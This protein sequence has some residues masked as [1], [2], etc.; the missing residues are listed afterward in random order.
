MK[1]KWGRLKV[2]QDTHEYDRVSFVLQ[3]AAA[4]AAAGATQTICLP[5]LSVYEGSS[6]GASQVAA[7]CIS[8]LYF[9]FNPVCSHICSTHKQNI[10]PF[11]RP[12]KS[13][14]R[15]SPESPRMLH[16]GQESTVCVCL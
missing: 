14:C 13:L 11:N 6:N 5:L 4:V 3:G 12:R 9:S 2:L 15:I 10:R 8:E 7:T 1:V 16:V